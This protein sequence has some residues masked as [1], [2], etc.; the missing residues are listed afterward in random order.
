MK[1]YCER[2]QE[3]LESQVREQFPLATDI[4]IHDGGI[5]RTYVTFRLPCGA[6][7]GTHVESD[8]EWIYH[9]TTKSFTKTIFPGVLS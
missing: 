5:T 8:S 1:L 2:L 6:G 9:P 7:S 3:R 4:H